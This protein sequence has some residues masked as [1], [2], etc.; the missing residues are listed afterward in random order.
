M[1][2]SLPINT[3]ATALAILGSLASYK[4]VAP[5]GAAENYLPMLALLG[6]SESARGLAQSK[7]FRVT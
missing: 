7:T 3:V 1:I 5:N 4:D 2:S 6:R